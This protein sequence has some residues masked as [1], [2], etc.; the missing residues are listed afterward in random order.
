MLRVV[1]TVLGLTSSSDDLPA[2]APDD[3]GMSARRLA[4]VDRVVTRGITAG[5]YPGAAVVVGRRGGIVLQRGFGHM[6]WGASAGGD[7]SVSNTLYDLASLTKVIGTTA[8]IMAL[9]DDGKLQLSDQVSRYL[10]EFGGGLNDE[11]TVEHLLTHR[12][13]LPAG[14][15]IWRIASSAPEARWAILATRAHTTPGSSFVYSDLGADVLGYLVE[16]VAHQPLDVY[17]HN[18]VFGPLRMHNTFFRPA[19]S[20]RHRI[21]PTAEASSRGSPLRGLVHDINAHV[22][23]G[24]SGHAGLFSTASDIAIFAQT[25][26]N[27][28]EYNGV[29]VFRDSTVS[30]FTR[31]TAG[32]RALGWDTAE[33]ELGAG[34]YLTS[35]AYGHTGYTG[36]SI[37]IDPDRDMFMILLTNRVH[38]PR[39]RYPMRVISDVRADVSDAAVLAV[40]DSPGGLREMPRA[41]RADQARGWNTPVRRAKRPAARRSARRR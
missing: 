30:R 18:R 19:D 21:A 14:R 16:A 40:A 24:V 41:F 12:A 10:P 37:W 31:R 4:V 28:G 17:L 13:G 33:G 22:Q 35:R 29:R 3:A 20:L 8:A 38:G 27:G 23:G 34:R 15:D 5:G 25:M 6:D 9:H 2:K 36:T 11:I 32:R 26:L 39:V 7:V 1:I